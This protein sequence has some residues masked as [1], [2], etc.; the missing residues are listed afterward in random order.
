[1]TEITISGKNLGALAVKSFCPRCFWIKMRCENNLPYQIFPGIFSSI[2]SYTKK[3]TNIHYERDGMIPKWLSSFGNLSRPV[4]SPHHSKFFIVDNKTNIRLS[5]TP[6]EIFQ[7]KDGSYFIADYKTAKYT[8]SQDELLPM[9]E[10]QLNAYAYIANRG[11]F[12]PVSGLGLVY[13]EPDTDLTSDILDPVLLEN[14][15][16]MAFRSKL[17]PIKLDP[18]NMILPLLEKVRT[19]IG[20]PS[21]PARS[22]G[23]KDCASIDR[24]VSVLSEDASSAKPVS[25][26]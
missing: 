19:I 16:Y 13:Y 10:V 21:P 4:K 2:D 1:M 11:E 5:G 7:R 18:E 8:A 20:T 12:S 6:D 17:H 14:G 9:Y 3:V 22:N 24:L 26:G 15:F 23:C 25:N